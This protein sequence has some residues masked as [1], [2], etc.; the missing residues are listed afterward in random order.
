MIGTCEDCGEDGVVQPRLRP[1]DNTMEELWGKEI[2]E[3]CAYEYGEPAEP[4][5]PDPRE[6]G[7]HFGWAGLRE[8]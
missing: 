8:D 5:R 6:D 2:C 7:G 4:W 1:S 3:D